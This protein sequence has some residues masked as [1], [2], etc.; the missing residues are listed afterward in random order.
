MIPLPVTSIASRSRSSGKF[1]VIRF[2]MID[3]LMLIMII[4]NTYQDES[5]DIFSLGCVLYEMVTRRRAFG[6]ANPGDTLAAILRDDPPPVDD[7]EMQRIL[8][9]CLEKNPAQRFQSARDLAFGLRAIAGSGAQAP[10]P[11][12]WQKKR[13]RLLHMVWIAASLAILLVAASNAS[14][15]RS[16][17]FMPHSLTSS[18]TCA[19]RWS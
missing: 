7:P 13:G 3:I 9:H 11:A 4:V 18:R 8:A 1:A 10:S 5:S 19:R 12:E 6:G 17:V 14:R 16:A 15:G 2:I